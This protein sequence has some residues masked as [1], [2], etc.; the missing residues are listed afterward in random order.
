[1]AAVTDLPSPPPAQRL[2]KARAETYRTTLRAWNTRA[3]VRP[4]LAEIAAQTG[5]YTVAQGETQ[6]WREMHVG[7]SCAA[8][9][10]AEAIRLG[11]DPPDVMLRCQGRE[12]GLEI[13]DAMPLDRRRGDEFNTLGDLDAAGEPLPIEQY[14]PDVDYATIVADVERVIAAKSASSTIPPISCW[15]SIFTTVCSH[16]WTGRWSV[17]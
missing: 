11:D 17:S 3:V 7:M 4:I 15:W 8:L 16:P 9:M 6:F 12:I 13:V 1:M 10:H 2:T 5:F 14:D